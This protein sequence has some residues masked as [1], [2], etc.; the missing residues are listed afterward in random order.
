MSVCQTPGTAVGCDGCAGLAGS[1][2]QISPLPLLLC[3]QG[4]T[5]S[6]A[7]RKPLPFF[8]RP[9][10]F[11]TLLFPSVLSSIPSISADPSVLRARRNSARLFPP[12]S[13]AL[14]CSRQLQ[15]AFLLALSASQ[16]M[17]WGFHLFSPPELPAFCSHL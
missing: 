9:S 12:R 5:S 2:L 3:F 8:L 17:P 15:W 1:P 16:T 11:S 6:A 7:S 13:C 14:T 4:V 10:G